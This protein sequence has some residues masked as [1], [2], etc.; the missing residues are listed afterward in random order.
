MGRFLEG[1]TRGLEI[2]R[3]FDLRQQLSLR[4][5]NHDMDSTRRNSNHALAMIFQCAQSFLLRWR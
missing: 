1:G 4:T 2:L 3:S 5:Y